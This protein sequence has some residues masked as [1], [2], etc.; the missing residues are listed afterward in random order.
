MKESA[1]DFIKRKNK[2]FREEKSLISMKDIGGKGRKF[3]FREAWT[4]L[5][6]SNLPN[7]V[8]I[9]ERLRKEK[10]TGKLAYPFKIG[11]IDYRIAYF[12]VSKAGRTKGKWVW[13]QFCPMIPRQDFLQLIKKAKKEKTVK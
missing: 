4:F 5:P 6:Q 10:F 9:L 11:A 3:Y 7:K 2:E 13:G 8:L 1:Q 12:I